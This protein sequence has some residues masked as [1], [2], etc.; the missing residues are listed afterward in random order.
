MLR[1]DASYA[2]VPQDTPTH[3]SL[4]HSATHDRVLWHFVV[5]PPRSRLQAGPIA[6]RCLL[7]LTQ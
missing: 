2:M 3:P 4:T 1:S 7:D 6:R 5:V